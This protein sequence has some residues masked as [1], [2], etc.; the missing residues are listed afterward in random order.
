[1]GSDEANNI[2]K[3]PPGGGQHNQRSRNAL[4]RLSEV[5]RSPLVVRELDALDDLRQEGKP[6]RAEYALSRVVGQ[7]D[8]ADRIDDVRRW[9]W[10]RAHRQLLECFADRKKVV[11]I[12]P[13]LRRFVEETRTDAWTAWRDEVAEQYRRL[14]GLHIHLRR[15]QDA[16]DAYG[17]CRD[18]LSLDVDTRYQLAVA[19]IELG[20]ADDSAV[21]IYLTYL[22][23]PGREPLQSLFLRVERGL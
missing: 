22:E 9:L 19:S 6:W 12:A 11:G 10:I 2:G 20:R 5:R 1:M 17:E 13:V 4:A 15:F 23:A 14:I 21:E 16:L 7:L 18:I 8:K 3:P